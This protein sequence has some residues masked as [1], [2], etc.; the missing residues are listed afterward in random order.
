MRRIGLLIGLALLASPVAA[1]PAPDPVVV[2]LFTAQGCDSCPQANALVAEL[3]ER[4]G[5]IA[6]TYAVDYW[7][8]LGWKDTFARPEFTER[9]RAYQAAMK[10]RDVYTP[11]V[12]VDGTIQ[13]SGVRGEAVE[14]AVDAHHARPD[15]PPEM[16][17][18]ARGRQIAIGSGRVP[19]GGAEV[20]LVRYQEGPQEVQIRAGDNR[21]QTIAHA[22][23]VRELVRLGDWR[24]RSRLYALP[25]AAEDDLKTVVLVQAVRT[26]RILGA[27]RL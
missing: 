8:Y 2:E 23:V 9:Q 17:F 16:L 18:R 7:D 25:A 11:Q 15:F 1:K 6:L 14:A 4:P 27:A 13:M 5:V 19:R 21:G 3:A 20:W 10:L 26:G 22:N 24:G 12:V